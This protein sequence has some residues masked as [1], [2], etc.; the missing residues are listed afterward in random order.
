ML[1]VFA[2]NVICRLSEAYLVN[3]VVIPQSPTEVFPLT[4]L[5]ETVES[6]EEIKLLDAPLLA[7]TS[8]C[9]IANQT[10]FRDAKPLCPI[11]SFKANETFDVHPETIKSKVIG[12]L[13]DTRCYGCTGYLSAGYVSGADDEGTRRVYWYTADNLKI[14]ELIDADE[15]EFCLKHKWFD[16]VSGV[17]FSL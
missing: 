10:H 15:F 7:K 12:Y 6:I 13:R 9:L 8:T 1:I 4:S 3:K 17:S 16:L 2:L 14:I 11:Q 5:K